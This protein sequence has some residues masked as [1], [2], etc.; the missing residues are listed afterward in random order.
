LHVLHGDGWRHRRGEAGLFGVVEQW[1]C[2]W[3]GLGVLGLHTVTTGRQ[4]RVGRFWAA[5]G[6]AG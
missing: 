6:L 3:V 4:R 1:D 2:W 5:Y